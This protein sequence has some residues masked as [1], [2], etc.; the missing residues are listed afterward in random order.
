MGRLN[1]Q[2]MYQSAITEQPERALSEQQAPDGGRDQ[3]EPSLVLVTYAS[4]K[5]ATTGVAGHIAAGLLRRELAVD[6]RPVEQ[7]RDLAMYHAVIL[8]AAVY[9]QEWPAEARE[10]VT[11]NLRTLSDMPL[12]LFSVGSFGDE[13]RFGKSI[14]RKE[15]RGITALCDELKAHD[16]RVFAGVVDRSQWPWFSRVF[17]RVSGGRF[18][19]NRDWAAIDAWAQQIALSLRSPS[20]AQR[21]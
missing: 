10:F 20:R 7:V 15:P 3:G 16:Y 9:N 12:W 4:R 2:R 13:G 14:V 6:L 18:G 11:R 8:G 5:G 17:F 19:D 1:A 21:T